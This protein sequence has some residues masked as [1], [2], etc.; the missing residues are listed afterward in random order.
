MCIHREEMFMAQRRERD[1]KIWAWRNGGRT[2]GTSAFFGFWKGSN[3][4]EAEAIK[5]FELWNLWRAIE[6]I[7]GLPSLTERYQAEAEMLYHAGISFYLLITLYL[8]VWSV[9]RLTAPLSEGGPL[10]L[11][12]WAPIQASASYNVMPNFPLGEG[13]ARLGLCTREHKR[14]RTKND[15]KT[16]YSLS[17]KRDK[18]PEKRVRKKPPLLSSS[19]VEHTRRRWKRASPE[20]SPFS[21]PSRLLFLP[22]PIAF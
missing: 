5:M 16:S 21:F 12:I 4:T 6:L 1:A 14:A 13:T 19:F 2:D 9:D 8:R 3:G 7:I 15:F 18:T 10:F 20:S 22:S 17:M 11:T